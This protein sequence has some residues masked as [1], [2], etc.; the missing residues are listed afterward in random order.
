[1]HPD[2]VL[3]P[4]DLFDGVRMDYTSIVDVFSQIQAPHGVL[5]VNGNHEE[6]RNTSEIHDA[7]T[8]ANNI[9]ILN[10]ETRRIGGVTFAGVGYHDTHEATDLRAAL[11]TLEL[12]EPTILLKHTPTLQDVLAEYPINLVVSGHT[13]HGQMWPF[14]LITDRMYGK[15]AYGHAEDGK[16]HSITTSGF[17]TW[18]P[19]QRLGTRSEIILIQIP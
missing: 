18:G 1:L 17:G 8:R 10:G 2:I 6:Y 5:F 4:G 11:D 15:Y 12:T 14:S 9:T 19:P 13:H 16:K 7:I 3:L